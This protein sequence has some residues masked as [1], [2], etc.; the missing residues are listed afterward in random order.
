MFAVSRPLSLNRLQSFAF[1]LLR[2][3]AGFLFFFHGSQKLLGWFGRPVHGF[4]LPMIAGCIELF[5]G[6]LIMLGLFTSVVAL[7]ASGEM[8]FAYWM[9]H[10]RRGHLP[11][12]N[13]GD[14]A[15]LF[16]FLFLF[17]FTMGGGPWS[18]DQLLFGRR[19]LRAKSA[20][21]EAESPAYAGQR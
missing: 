8:A 5:G 10:F 15:V 9:V 19:A 4:G 1:F 3:V 21:A 13:G 16:C 20:S 6:T 11:I 7:I 14:L 12:Q 2:V 17:L 18:L